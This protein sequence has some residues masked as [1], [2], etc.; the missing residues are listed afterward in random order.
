MTRKFLFIVLLIGSI[1]GTS[2]AQNV[3][4]VA[5]PNDSLT[6]V[7]G[8]WQI[9]TID[10]MVLKTIQFSHQEYLSANH[11]ISVVEL[12]ALAE[13]N[14]FRTMPIDRGSK[15][16]MSRKLQAKD[17]VMS[18]RQNAQQSMGEDRMVS[19]TPRLS[20]VQRRY[21]LAFS[22]RPK[23]AVTSQQG[24]EE[25]AVAA[26][27][28]SFFDMDYD[29]PI[30]FLRIENKQVGENVPGTDTVNRKYYQTASIGLNADGTVA[31][32]RTQ[33]DRKWELANMNY[34]SVMTAGPLLIYHDT[35]Q[36]MRTDRTFVTDRHNRTALG[37]RPDGTVI[38]VTVDGRAKEA[39]GMS[40]NELIATMHY[41]GC[42]DAVNLDGGGST[43]L[44]VKGQPNNGVVNY[45]SDNGI[46]DHKGERAVS[47]CILV[48]PIGPRK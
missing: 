1:T 41:L 25:G 17:E 32:R 22:Y 47:S 6:L 3:Q 37:I 19:R 5:T 33:P 27:N 14:H 30:C 39:A 11:Y 36:T 40:L 34:P 7:N 28:G 29:N 26:I 42:V 4:E 24:A 8:K 44:W 20:P 15:D 12:P 35:M 10:G 9:D 43:T 18:Q 48:K 31:I 16:R 45:P 13:Q 2:C 21:A 38:L 46:F 23:R